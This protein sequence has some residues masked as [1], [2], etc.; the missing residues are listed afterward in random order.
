LEYRNI[1]AY[2]NKKVL[3]WKTEKMYLDS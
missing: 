1:Y 2:N 3:I